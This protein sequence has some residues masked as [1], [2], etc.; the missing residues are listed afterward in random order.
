MNDH[1]HLT[2]R[3][4]QVAKEGSQLL[5]HHLFRCCAIRNLGEKHQ[6]WAEQLIR[7]NADQSLTCGL[8]LSL[9]IFLGILRVFQ[10]TRGG[11]LHRFKEFMP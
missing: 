5:L 4:E 11:L 7:L 2:L 8:Q 9:H 10:D 1:L 6:N 3:A